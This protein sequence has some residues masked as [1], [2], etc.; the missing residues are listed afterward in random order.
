MR[1][2]TF[3]RAARSSTC[4]RA[5]QD[6]PSSK[7]P[8]GFI[9][10]LPVPP[11][12]VCTFIARCTASIDNSHTWRGSGKLDMH[13]DANDFQYGGH[14]AFRHQLSG[15]STTGYESNL[16]RMHRLSS[17]RSRLA[18]QCPCTVSTTAAHTSSNTVP[19]GSAPDTAT[20]SGNKFISESVVGAA[21]VAPNKPTTVVRIVVEA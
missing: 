19:H 21:N 6:A 18:P 14:Y 12:I 9:L 5:V 10:I 17:A 16:T 8:S 15:A 2:P 13:D 4:R 20:N 1:M 3:D 7:S 11:T